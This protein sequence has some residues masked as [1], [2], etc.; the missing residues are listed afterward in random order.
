MV[1]WGLTP[2][3]YSTPAIEVLT[4]AASS[5]GVALP[6]HI[7]VDTGMHHVGAALGEA[8]LLAK[9]VEVS[10][11]LRLDGFW[12][13]FAVAEEDPSFTA[14]QLDR[15]TGALAGLAEAG[16]APPVVHAANTAG[17]LGREDAR[18]SMVRLGLGMYGL[19]PAP[20]VGHELDLRP[21]M[22]VVTH[23]T[24]V[25]RYPAGTAA[26]LRETPAAVCRGHR[27]HPSHRVRRR[28][29]RETLG[30]SAP[31]CWSAAGASPSPAR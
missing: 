26:V 22:R 12:T 24:H 13:H 2:T 7:K 11:A 1:E 5:A 17:A 21:A 8:L 3:V 28:G 14:L 27:R 29:G 20:H 10:A 19:R 15:F 30:A 18:F 25:R 23:V 4:A 9:S 16:I 6:V 31:R